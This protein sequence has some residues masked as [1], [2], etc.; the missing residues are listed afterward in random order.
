MSKHTAE[1]RSQQ[2]NFEAGDFEAILD[3]STDNIKEPARAP[4]GPWVVRM[5][6]FFIRKTSK[7][8]LEADPEAALGQVIFYHTPYEPLDGVDP[9]V[10]EAGEWRGKRIATKRTIKTPGD[11]KK[12]LDLAVMHGVDPEGRS[13]RQTLEACKN[14]LI[15]GTVS[16]Y[17]YKNK[18]TGETVVENQISNFAPAE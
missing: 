16:V 17:S 11:D 7:E 4:S 12:V 6:G 3:A 1:N 15:R 10:V 8:D 2:Q 5:T 9:E 13:L 18:T 14:R